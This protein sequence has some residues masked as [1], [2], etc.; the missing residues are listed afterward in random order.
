MKT[1]ENK[2]V[3]GSMAW[4]D[5]IPDWLLEAVRVERMICG[6]AGIIGK[7]PEEEQEVGDA[8]VCV[9]LYT[10]SLAAPL[11]SEMTTIYLYLTTKFMQK[12]K[13]TIPKDIRVEQLTRYEQSE[14]SRLKRQLYSK[15]GGEINHPLFDVMKQLKKEASKKFV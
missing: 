3:V 6:L 5:T 9:Y 1:K 2:L 14:L 8:E 12:R 10:A 4:S 7:G 15:R 11:D 13:V